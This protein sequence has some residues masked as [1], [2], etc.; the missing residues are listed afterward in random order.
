MLDTAP[1]RRLHGDRM[2]RT[3]NVRYT[4]LKRRVFNEYTKFFRFSNMKPREIRR[5]GNSAA[6]LIV[7]TDNISIV[8]KVASTGSSV[9]IKLIN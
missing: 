7:E 1:R 2:F 6:C 8:P 5:V 9:A 4:S 3:T